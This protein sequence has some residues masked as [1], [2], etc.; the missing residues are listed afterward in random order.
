MSTQ[1]LL[2]YHVVEVSFQYCEYKYYH[3]EFTLVIET[4]Y[5]V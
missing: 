1:I 5:N 2:A 4:E 3:I